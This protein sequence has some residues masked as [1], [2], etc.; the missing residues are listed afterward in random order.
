MTDSTLR[1]RDSAT[2]VDRG[3]VLQVDLAGDVDEPELRVHAP[4]RGPR[5]GVGWHRCRYVRVPVSA[6][7]EHASVRRR[8]AHGGAPHRDAL[9]VARA[10]SI[11]SPHDGQH[12][13]V[14]VFGS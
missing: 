3:R 8:R 14:A 12:D 9:S 1:L 11:G 6:H 7:Y 4:D 5:E 2:P 13:A 10:G